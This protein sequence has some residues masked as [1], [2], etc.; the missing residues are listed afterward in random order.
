MNL[1]FMRELHQRLEGSG[2]TV[3]CVHPGVVA[4]NIVSANSG[5]LLKLGWAV[6]SLFMLS[7][8]KGA[9][10]SIKVASDPELE[11]TSDKYFDKEAIARYNKL[12][13]D[14]ELARNLW[15]ATEKL[16]ADART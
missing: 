12:A 13:D 8:E 15:I 14:R 2:V 10:T 1:L 3:N 11:K 16:I 5:P 6:G 7:P 9:L 4:T